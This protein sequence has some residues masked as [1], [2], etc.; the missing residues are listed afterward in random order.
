MTQ[1]ASYAVRY[2]NGMRIPSAAFALCVLFAA[3]AWAQ[4]R[5]VAP[6]APVVPVAPRLVL[7]APA[8]TPSLP[9]LTPAPPRLTP[10]LPGASAQV[11]S[12]GPGAAL[13]AAAS[14][15][16][17]EFAADASAQLALLADDIAAE[18]G[19]RAGQMSGGDFLAVVEEAAARYAREAPGAPS[20]PA[21][22]AALKVQAATLRVA[23]A[24]LKA[25]QP[26][27]TQ[28]RRLLSVWQVFNQEMVRA[29][30]EK[31]TLEGVVS[32]AELFASQVEAS[33]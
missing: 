13:P 19:L 8:L 3:Q 32:E 4:V 11:P 23:R 24:L 14:K 25:E 33:I 15:A 22:E 7:P 27:G 1:G 16:E 18:A 26:L 17:L 21:R 5:F 28:I 12:V 9:N 6:V 29:A 20:A 31:G 30:E 10:A 2:P